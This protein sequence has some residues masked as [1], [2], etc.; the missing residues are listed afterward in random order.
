VSMFV[1]GKCT[2]NGGNSMGIGAINDQ[3]V[4]LGCYGGEN[5]KIVLCNKSIDL[6]PHA[7]S[8]SC[9]VFKRVV[10]YGMT[11]SPYHPCTIDSNLRI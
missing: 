11:C 1:V 6:M 7:A 5:H 10:F 9:R 4:S 8:V 2:V 3:Y